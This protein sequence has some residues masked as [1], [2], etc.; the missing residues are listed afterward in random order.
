MC[1][2]M[3][4]CNLSHAKINKNSEWNEI[5]GKMNAFEGVGH[6]FKTN[7]TMVGSVDINFS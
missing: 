1:V 4:E 7:F 3:Y 2:Y 5:V 6:S